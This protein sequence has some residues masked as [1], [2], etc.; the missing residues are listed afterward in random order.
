MDTSDLLHLPFILPSQ[1]QKHVTHNEAL[2]MLDGLVQLAVIDR[3]LAEPPE[4]TSD[5]DRYIVAPDATGEWAG[6]SGRIAHRSAGGWVFHD[7]QPGWVAWLIDEQRAAFW[8][9]SDWQ[10]VADAITGLQNLSL[11]GV[12]TTADDTNPFAAKLN[13]ALWTA[14]PISEGGDGDLRYTLNKESAS[15]VLS[16]LMQ[17]GFSGRA[18]L[19]LTG[20]DDFS[21]KVSPDGSAWTTAL[22]ADRTTGRVSLAALDPATANDATRKSYVDAQRDTRVAKGGDTMSGPLVLPNGAQAAP[23]LAL[24]AGNRGLYYSTAGCK[25][26]VVIDGIHQGWFTRGGSFRAR[27]RYPYQPA[28]AVLRR[29]VTAHAW[30]ASTS[31]ADNGW[32]SIA[33]SPELGL[34]CAVSQTGTGNRVMTSPDGI[35]WTIRTS[36]SD[37]SWRSVCWS[38][39]LGLFCA[40]ASS[41]AQVMTSPDGIVWTGHTASVSN[42]WF[43]VCWAPEPG[44][45]C[46]VSQNGSGNRVMTSPDGINWTGRTSAA[47]NNWWSVCW[48]PELALFC[49]VAGTGGGNRVMTSP[50]GIAW[51][52]QTSAADNEWRSVCWSPELGLFCAVAVTGSGN[53]VMT[54]PDG[55]AWTARTSAADNSW[56]SV[57]W[58]PVLGL[59]CAVASS[60]TND[61]VMTSPDGVVWT[62]RTS[63]ANNTWVRVCWSP[64]LGLFCAIGQSGTGNRAMTSV[65]AFTCPYRS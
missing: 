52:A 63:A 19:G 44:L 26:H 34:F 10:G 11:L 3:H 29:H 5:G 51:T 38:S 4:A 40:V 50:D 55:V 7:P 42:S 35:V 18:E 54:S 33:W 30:L 20:S 59:F 62:T 64:E 14:R 25:M 23:A 21:L 24:G 48:A 49:A 43:S 8:D 16:L 65:S 12:G 45:F 28:N 6:R 47:D 61:R 37:N 41:G 53:R 36:A 56:Q 15:D 13:K 32:S 57:D 27:R 1:S 9:G 39:E 2:S 17:S 31:A 46:A 22:S 60:G 58:S